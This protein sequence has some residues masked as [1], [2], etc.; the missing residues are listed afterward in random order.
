MK[1]TTNFI[2]R[3]VSEDELKNIISSRMIQ[4][5][6]LTSIL[7]AFVESGAECSEVTH[8]YKSS[9]CARSAFAHAIMNAGMAD[10]VKVVIRK[11]KLFLIRLA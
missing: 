5:H 9:R 4:R 7:R 8:C 6:P 2:L 1:E 11:N 10:I 3:P